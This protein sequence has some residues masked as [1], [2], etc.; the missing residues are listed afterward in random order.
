[1]S[2][3]IQ[4]VPTL[5]ATLNMSR[6]YNSLQQ[7]VKTQD[8]NNMPTQYAYDGAGNPVVIQD[9]ADNRIIANYDD[10]G[11]KKWVNDPN[12]GRSD[13]SYNDFGELEKEIDANSAI[14]RYDVDHL[15]RVTRRDADGSTARFVWDT[16]KHGL[17]S[18]HDE[19]GSNKAFQYDAAARVTQTT[20]TIDGTAYHV[21]T[22]YDG[23]F[24]RPKALQ[25]PE[26][27]VVVE[28]QYNAQGYLSKE[29]NAQSGFV[30]REVT[31]QD[32][33]GNIQNALINDGGLAGTYLYH[34]SSGQML[35][36]W[37]KQGNE[38]KHYLDYQL[39]DS[40]GNL[41][42]Q[43]NGISNAT[44]TFHYDSLHRLDDSSLSLSGFS[45]NIDYAYDVVGNLQ[46]KSDYSADSANAY[47]Y[48]A[49]SN[50]LQKVTLKDSSTV[51]FGYDLK[52][53]QTHRNNNQEVS[54]NSFNKPLTISKNASN[55]KLAYGADLARYKQVRVVD[56]K[57]ITTHYIDKLYEVE[58]EGAKHTRKSY[59]SDVAI[60]TSSDTS[61][62]SIAF[63][64]RDRLG[65]A[66]TM[67]DHNNAVV[68]RRHFDPFGKPRAGDWS[69]LDSFGLKAQLSENLLDAVMATRR[70]FTDH[71]H[72]D[73]AE[74]IHMNG[75]VY[76]YNVGRFMSVDP[77]IQ[78]PGNSQSINP[79]SYIMNNPLSGTDPTGY[80]SCGDGAGGSA[81]NCGTNEQKAQQT[82]QVTRPGSRIKTTVTVTGSASNGVGTFAIS[83]GSASARNTVMGALVGK[84]NAAG[85]Q[86]MDVGMVGGGGISG[87]NVGGTPSGNT[88]TTNTGETP[89][90]SEN[91]YLD[92]FTS[93]FNERVTQITDAADNAVDYWIERDN[94]IMGTLAA[95]MTKDN[96]VNTTVTL[97]TGGAGG[98]GLGVIR[99]GYVNSLKN[100]EKFK[101]ALLSKGYSTE[102]VARA[103]VRARNLTK[104]YWRGPLKG[105]MRNYH[106]PSSQQLMSEKSASKI[107]ERAFT[108]NKG[109]DRMLG[110]K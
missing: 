75:R 64:H 73:E 65:S 104:D 30:Y 45:S 71:E 56:G 41:L 105:I 25:Y 20:T 92:A 81:G 3:N 15:G 79:Y 35:S 82:V 13:F 4:V 57:T 76:D 90:A 31:A 47:T 23:N 96:I 33:L 11:R 110:A 28:L 78:A 60:L 40:Y 74:L 102:G 43:N 61:G 26:N 42:T 103:L 63:T 22:Q 12:Q 94:P 87:T 83:G 91:S 101:G 6:T 49:N 85:L 8:A 51:T 67:T 17:L 53:N 108:S 2:T 109:V 106:R 95:T 89:G 98:A 16:Q 88:V 29:L 9:A 66:A 54:Y 21:Q 18:S 44:E 24:G 19:A 68:S 34:G 36:T 59:I 97:G 84:A 14:I 100:L 52:G 46:K 72:L 39:Y 86:V 70:G 93:K 55:I 27:G 50:K 107:I 37:V 58:I 48:V 10:L 62:Q 77:Y 7:L 1:L 38:H 80:T 5:G 99:Q 32:N 69:S